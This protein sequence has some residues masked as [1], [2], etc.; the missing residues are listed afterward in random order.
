MNGSKYVKLSWR[1]NA[2]LNIEN[3]DKHCFI[4]SIL[5]SLYLFDNNH[6]HRVSKYKKNLNEL[7]II[8]FDFIIGFKCSDVH[9]FNEINNLSI[10]IF[11]I[12]FYQDQNKWR[13]K[14]IPI[15]ISKNIP[16]RLLI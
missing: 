11:E 10:N 14:L 2:I 16:D 12:N 7:N 8:G 9:R 1:S 13:D 15:E 3:N 6:P 5:A 4:W